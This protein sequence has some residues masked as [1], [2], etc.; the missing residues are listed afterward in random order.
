MQNGSGGG[1][2]F[3]DNNYKD[4]NDDDNKNS[5]IES[6]ATYNNTRNYNKNGLRDL[7]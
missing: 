4:N 3:D 1:D 6:Y 5:I 2:D 7:A